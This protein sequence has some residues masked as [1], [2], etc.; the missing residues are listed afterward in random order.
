MVIILKKNYF[1]RFVKM[2]GIHCG[3]NICHKNERILNIE[4]NFKII[5]LKSIFLSKK[6]IKCSNMFIQ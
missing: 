4:N 5:F 3:K 1:P 6:K 2:D